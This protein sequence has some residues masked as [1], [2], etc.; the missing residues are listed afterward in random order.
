MIL[1]KPTVVKGV[2]SVFTLN[3][4]ELAALITDPLYAYYADTTHW[5]KVVIIYVSATGNQSEPVIFNPQVD[6]CV[7]TFEVSPFAFDAFNVKSIVI[8]DFD[9]GPY[10]IPA[11]ALNVNDFNISFVA[12]PSEALWTRD[13]TQADANDSFFNSSIV[14]NAYQM[15]GNTSN[16]QQFF[17]SGV[18]A[19]PI[20]SYEVRIHVESSD[21]VGPIT[22]DYGS[23]LAFG[24]E[25]TYWNSDGFGTW[26]N[27][28]VVSKIINKVNA[29]NEVFEMRNALIGDN[30]NYAGKTIRI[31]KIEIYGINSESILPLTFVAP[32]NFN[33]VGN[34]ADGSFATDEFNYCYNNGPIQQ[35]VADLGSVQTGVKNLSLGIVAFGGSMQWIPTQFVVYGTNDTSG[36]YTE[37]KTFNTVRADWVHSTRKDFD[38]DTLQSYRYFK[39]LFV[40]LDQAQGASLALSEVAF[41]K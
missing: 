26:V 35:I 2:A 1:T 38:F 23:Y 11:S 34:P 10:E 4:T 39:V 32:S 30:P 8:H 15:L 27:G 41:Y 28:Q 33:V 20:G 14:S 17:N 12:P 9:N 13:F 5:R 19:L 36:A 3:K 25:R 21:V 37:I 40:S 31:S 22:Q 6:P 29:T 24:A 7:G 18:G 16:Q